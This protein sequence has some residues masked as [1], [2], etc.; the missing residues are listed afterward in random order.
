[1]NRT[2]RTFLLVLL[3]LFIFAGCEH[4]AGPKPQKPTTTKIA[5]PKPSDQKYIYHTIKPGE[6]MGTISQWYSGTATRWHEIQAANPQAD[7][8]RLRVGEVLK[9]PMSMAVDHTQQPGFSTAPKRS[10]SKKAAPPPGD[11]EVTPEP[12][13]G[14]K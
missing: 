2:L 12:V 4:F 7:T 1:M 6:T 11:G 5:K 3:V 13:F 14:P 10:K 8:N 9:I